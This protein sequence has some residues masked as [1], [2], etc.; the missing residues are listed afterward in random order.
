[1]TLSKFPPL[2][3]TSSTGNGL[4]ILIGTATAYSAGQLTWQAALVLVVPAVALLLFPQ[5]TALSVAAQSTVEDVEK[6]VTAYKMGLT[7][8]TVVTTALTQVAA[9]KAP[10][11]RVP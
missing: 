8:A 10:F 7:H 5:N 9:P 11:I 1:M 3:A 2:Q 4:A 6:L